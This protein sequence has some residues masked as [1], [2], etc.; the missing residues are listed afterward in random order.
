MTT[1][2]PLLL[3]IPRNEAWLNVSDIARGVG[4]TTAVQISITLNDMLQPLQNEMEYYDQRLYDFLWLAHLK[5]SLDRSQSATFNFT[6]PR[7][8]WKTEEVSEVSLRV[9]VE[10]QK[11]VVLLGLLEDF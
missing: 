4:F 7:K 10:A 6:F 9:R 8:D 2:A 5:L 11:Q 1:S 3:D